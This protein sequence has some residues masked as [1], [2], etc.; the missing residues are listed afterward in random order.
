[1]KVLAVSAHPDDETLGCGGTLL[2]HAAVGDEISWLIATEAFEPQWPRAVID[3]KSD[4][5]AR[6]AGAY[7]MKNVFRLRLPTTRLDA[8]PRAELIDGVRSVIAEAGP[9]I[10][11]LVH[12]GD[13]H[14]DHQTLFTATMA[15]LKPSY[16]THFGV[17]RVLSFEVLSS[18]EAAP[19]VGERAFVPTVFSDI[20]AE[21]EQ[22]LAIMALYE[23]EVHVDPLPRAASA[24][25][26]LARFRGAT[27]GVEY[28]EAF[29][30]IRE[31]I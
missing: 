6:V 7:E 25:R 23:T 22:K 12:R 29:M 11:Y 27:V 15:V 31:L 4:E 14:T 10:V 28:A 3:R 26:A 20:S 18:T 21:L 2:K 24:I 9:A 1:M 13:V 8:M 17:Q 30:L 5:V 16:M 19:P